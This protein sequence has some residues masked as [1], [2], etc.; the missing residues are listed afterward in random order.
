[1]NTKVDEPYKWAAKS[2]A[3]TGGSAQKCTQIDI[4]KL[5][6]AINKLNSLHIYVCG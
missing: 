3:Q 6:T 2:A 4:F 5:L 1:M